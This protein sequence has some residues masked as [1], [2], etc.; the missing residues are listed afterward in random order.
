MIFSKISTGSPLSIWTKIRLLFAK[1]KVAV[2]YGSADGD[3]TVFLYLKRLGDKVFVTGMKTITH[4][5]KS[6]VGQ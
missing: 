1:R 4:K 3:Y 6:N 5:E 2:D